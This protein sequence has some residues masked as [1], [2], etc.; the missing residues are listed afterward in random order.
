MIRNIN[1]KLIGAVSIGNLLE[2]YDFGLFSTFSPLFAKLFFPEMDHRAAMLRVFGIF[3]VGFLC[4]P[5]GAILF[6]HLGDRIGRIRTLRISILAIGIPTLLIAC[7]PTYQSIGIYASIFLLLLRVF[8]G[9]SLGGEF[10]GIII[11]LTETSPLKNRAFSASFAGTAANLG[12][13]CGMGVV[14]V[15]TNI[16]PIEKYELFGWRI[17]FLIGGVLSVW[18]VYVR[19]S[20]VETPI[21]KTLLSE[22]KILKLPL[23]Q[24]FK[25]MP[26]RMLKIMGL[27]V[28]GSIFYYT[29]YGYFQEYWVDVLHFS[30]QKGLTIQMI[31]LI[32]ML[33]LVPLGGM[34]CDKLGRRKSFIWLTGSALL[35][36]LPCFYLFQTGWMM[37]LIVG[38]SVLTLISSME[39]GTTS[40]TV[41]EQ[42]PPEFRYSALSLSYNVTQ[43]LFG[44]TA[45]LVSAYLIFHTENPTMPVY[46]LMAA[47]LVTL[48][49]VLFTLKETA[50]FVKSSVNTPSI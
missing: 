5:L 8:Q 31:A 50:P 32:S 37:G 19:L 24:A 11:Y 43:A 9:I 7:I 15:L 45:P 10:T 3:A 41:V 29:C 21:F 27:I 18:V 49:V 23:K 22:K 38:M 13:L 12:I 30:A 17:A 42:V 25:K 1:F 26:L 35:L 20:L 48:V 4:R 36:S 2:W 44:G 28:F 33:F 6:G 34:L 46:Y 40:V 47:A 14:Y 16:L 39:Q